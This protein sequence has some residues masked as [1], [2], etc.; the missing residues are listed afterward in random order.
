MRVSILIALLLAAGCAEPRSEDV[1]TAAA[2]EAAPPRTDEDRR[3]ANDYER[4]MKAASTDPVPSA[5]YQEEVDWAEAQ[6]FGRLDPAKLPVTEG[7][8]LDAIRVPV[9]AFGDD[10]RLGKALLTHNENWYA[11]TATHDG[12]TMTVHGTRNAVV[13]PGMEIPAAAREAADNYVL[14]RA[15]GVVTVTWRAFGLSYGLDV[16]CQKPMEDPR[17]TQDEFAL[18][19]AEQLGVIGGRP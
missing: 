2:L 6:Q 15:H 5:T 16:E 3:A 17:C 19:V 12:V 7:A 11:L 10:A 9:L 8:K 1:T 13:V 18:Q 14:T 4:K